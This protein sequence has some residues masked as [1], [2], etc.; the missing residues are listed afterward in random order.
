M[1]KKNILYFIFI[2]GLSLLFFLPVKSIAQQW[3]L[4]TL[5][6]TKNG[7]KA[8][9]VDTSDSPVTY[10]QWTFATDK[11]SAYSAYLIAGDTLV[12][13]YKPTTNTSWN[14]GGIHG[15]IQKVLWDGTVVWDYTYYSSTYCAHHD[16]C[17]LPNGNVLI[18][19][20]DV[21]SQAE[22]TQAGSSQNKGYW[23]DKVIEVKPTGPTTGTIV[24]E[25]KLWDHLCQ[26]Y[27]ATKDNYV[28]SIINNPQLMNINYVNAGGPP[29]TY[30]DWWHM[31]GIDY[32]EELD[33]IVVSAHFMNSVFVIDHSTTT[34][35]AAGHTGGNSGKGGD[36]LYRWGNPAS[37]DATGTTIFNTIHDAHWVSSDNPNYPNYLAAYNNN[38]GT[39]GK[40]AI[41][42]WNPPYNGY[43]Y[44]LTL[45]QAYTPSSYAY[46]Y[47]ASFT[48]NNEGNSHQLPNGNM[49]VNNFQG[50]IYEVNSA[51]TTIWTK[52]AAMSTH[53]YR[54]S[55]C[56]VRGPVAN[57]GSSL[58]SVCS[59]S[60]ITLSSS[61]TSVTETNPTYSYSWESIPA[62]FVSSSQNPTDMPLTSTT[63]L[64]T[65]TN[66]ALGCSDTT[67]VFVNVNSLPAVPT[68]S[69]NQNT[70]T[71]STALSYQWYY[72]SSIM[73]G[74]TNQSLNPAVDGTYQVVISDA[75][76][77]TSI[78]DPYTY[79]STGIS[80]MED[81]KEVVIYPNPTKGLLTLENATESE[82]VLTNSLGAVLEVKENVNSLD[83]SKYPDGI[84][85]IAI[86]SKEGVASY[87]K[88]ILIK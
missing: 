1:R 27:N 12:R 57:A 39:G 2:A 47:N 64:V 74:E 78:S 20:Y 53:A 7:T 33:Q 54:Y 25:W 52:T 21:K 69:E 83:M 35:E 17:P 63:Y 22:A 73:P 14:S 32:N 67:H 16:I 82:L 79:I 6:A 41:D 36:F 30:L 56:F 71:S 88:I 48:A 81:V 60:Q 4:Y 70:L 23:S 85:Y 72:N 76:G 11:K 26:N 10:H 86:R 61:G 59:G 45:G 87:Q 51:G 18:I 58:A 37:Y 66:T 62:G 15:G 8:Y 84:Y 80:L 43:N 75:N 3:G 13:S 42:V 19:S 50:S 28:T 29:S 40:T 55:K 77:C 34:A 44:D 46:Q 9:L 38:G 49:L 24:W 31:N 68:I 5:Y 65:V